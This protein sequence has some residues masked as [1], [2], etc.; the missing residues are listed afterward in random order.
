MYMSGWIARH[1]GG[2]DET[3]P[4]GICVPSGDVS[5]WSSKLRLRTVNLHTLWRALS[6]LL[7]VLVLLSSTPPSHGAPPPPPTWAIATVEAGVQSG[8]STSIALDQAGNP[9]IAYSDFLANA[10][11]YV[12]WTGGNWT[13]EVVDE[14]GLFT[15]DVSL[16]LDAE[17]RPHLGYFDGEIG[18]QM[19][20]V[21]NGSLWD[22]REVEPSL[23]D[24]HSSLAL[25]PSGTPHLAYAF[26]NRKVRYAAW[27]GSGWQIE[28]VDPD[29]ITAGSI[30][31]ALDSLGRPHVAYYG[32]EVLHYAY[33][34][35]T[36]WLREVVDGGLDVGLFADLALDSTNGR[37]IG[38]RDDSNRSFRYATKD[39]GRDEW[40]IEVVDSEGDTGWD[41][42]I[43]VDSGDRVQASHYERLEGE[44][45]YAYREGSTWRLQAVDSDGVVGFFTSLA[46]DGYD[47]PHISYFDWS[48]RSIKYAKDSAGVAVQTLTS[49]DVG[50]TSST[51][52][53]EVTSLGG[54][55]KVN[56]S[57]DWR[58]VRRPTDYAPPEWETTEPQSLVEGGIVERQ[59]VNLTP[60]SDF[61]SIQGEGH[62]WILSCLWKRGLISNGACRGSGG[63]ACSKPRTPSCGF[64]G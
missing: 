25:D 1:V 50:A 9:H 55:P 28:T 52:R 31:L 42:D 20:A 19:Y 27:N 62:R 6:A 4:S 44:L 54:Y 16:A 26:L 60:D 5:R 51:L 18:S 56:A 34:N 23:S 47:L 12:S 59:L 10:L 29:V 64:S 14:G 2:I 57:F 30:S 36:T 15:G 17:D 40:H 24:G 37:H 32:I 48:R 21:Q 53:G 13:V 33:W 61:E 63:R 46:L 38:Y 39:E 45:R 41:I 58:P 22:L 8:F 35:G 43:E 7:I 3:P 11:K 49:I